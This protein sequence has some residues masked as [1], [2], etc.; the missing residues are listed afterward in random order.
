MKIIKNCDFS[1]PN[2]LLEG[3]E[4]AKNLLFPQKSVKFFGKTYPEFVF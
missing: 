3:A 2:N 4:A 1:M